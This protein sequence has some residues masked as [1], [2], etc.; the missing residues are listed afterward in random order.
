MS[1]S[2]EIEDKESIARAQLP[3]SAE[4]CKTSRAKCKKCQLPMEAGTLKLATMV[5]SRFHDG[6]DA[7]FFHLECFFRMKMPQSVAE[8][9]HFSTLKYNDQKMLEEAVQ[10]GAISLITK[11]S[12]NGNATK[13]NGNNASELG[14]EK[15]T[16]KGNKKKRSLKENGE[17]DEKNELCQY[18][19][20]SVEYAKSG[21]AKCKRCDQKIDKDEVR[22]G[23]LDYDA[24]STFTDGP[25]MRWYHVKCFANSLT[26]LRFFGKITKVNGFDKLNEEDQEMLQEKIKEIKLKDLQA[27]QEEINK[28]MK[29]DTGKTSK[30][31]E[32]EEKILKKQ[33]DR[34]YAL[35][36]QVDKIRRKDLEDI[37]EHMEQRSRFRTTTQLVDWATDVL[38]FG[39]IKKCPTCKQKGTFKLGAG[40]YICTGERDCQPC[41]YETREP[42]RSV[43][44]IPDEIVEDYPFFEED[45]KFSPKARIFS[46]QF[47]Q[48]VDKKE[49]E[50]N[51]IVEEGGPLEGLSI[52]IISWKT[53]DVDKIKIQK[54]VQ[55]LGGSVLTSLDKSLYAII[56]NEEQLAKNNDPKVEVA[57]E[58][59]V[60]FV[61]VQFIFEINSKDDLDKKLKEYLITA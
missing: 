38:M 18:D 26:Q 17:E 27:Q 12:S 21:R 9:A 39:P 42:K 57:K 33:S 53:L 11:K 40:G 52:G 51:N 7:K 45:Y 15:T 16:K 5:K 46:S 41:T 23:R 8:I 43:P 14:G 49:A 1:Q 20:F 34:Y 50:V 54:K 6:Y 47:L 58:L 24:E 29:I 55:M 3:Y 19:D 44:D 37:L 36:E 56:T 48:E 35:R 28:K 31:L 30:E 22:L 32:K 60:P 4:Y 25:L 10:S 59:G 2:S 61:K 13:E